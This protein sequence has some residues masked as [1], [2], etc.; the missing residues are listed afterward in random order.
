M[1]PSSFGDALLLR[2]LPRPLAQHTI[3]SL[4]SGICL[5][6]SNQGYL[7]PLLCQ[8]HV[9][10][11]PSQQQGDSPWLQRAKLPWAAAQEAQ[12]ALT[13]LT[14]KQYGRRA[15]GW[16]LLVCQRDQLLNTHMA[17][18]ATSAKRHR[19]ADGLVLEWLKG[20]PSHAHAWSFQI[21][22]R[23]L[24]SAQPHARQPKTCIPRDPLRGIAGATCG[25]GQGGLGDQ[26][27]ACCGQIESCSLSGLER[28]CRQNKAMRPMPAVSI[29]A[30]VGQAQLVATGAVY[31]AGRPPAGGALHV[32][33]GAGCI[34][35]GG[36][37]LPERLAHVVQ[38]ILTPYWDRSVS[39]VRTRAHKHGAIQI[40]NAAAAPPGSQGL[41]ADPVMGSSASG[42]RGRPLV[43]EE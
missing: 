27:M 17:T 26:T 23:Q 32:E 1:L 25:N 7:P 30:G 3:T 34:G 29:G 42:R 20:A 9:L 11:M 21:R 4:V 39:G 38:A 5:Q 41:Q 10:T 43:G 18:R 22:G 19:L 2:C 36:R 12:L 35:A 28:Q 37:L 40:S 24:L 8:A 16:V 31:A 15:E 33:A 14:V 6:T 13:C